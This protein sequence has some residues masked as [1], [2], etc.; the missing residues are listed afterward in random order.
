M[1]GIIVS[2]IYG[3]KISKR[4]KIRNFFKLFRPP[5]RNALTDLDVSTP[6]CAQ[7]C[8]LHI[9]PHL[10]T[11]RKIEMVAVLC[12]NETAPQ[13][14]LA[15]T[16]FPP[17]PRADGPQRGRGHVGRHYPCTNKIWCGSVH[18]LLRYRSRT[19]KMQKFPID[20]YHQFNT[21]SRQQ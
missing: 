3:R 10:A 20:S 19:A 12:M 8:V 6:E 11:L 16:P 1:Y 2:E 13:F 15:L 14:F 17:P 21:P 18:A 7:V 9:E 5:C 4:W